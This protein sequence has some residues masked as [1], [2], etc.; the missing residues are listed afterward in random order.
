VALPIG[1]YISKVLMQRATERN[2]ENLQTATD[3]EKRLVLLEGFAH[4]CNLELVVFVDDSIDGFIVA[5]VPVTLGCDVP[6]A[7]N[8]NPIDC[9][10]EHG[11]V[12]CGIREWRYRHH[13]ASTPSDCLGVFKP[14]RVTVTPNS[15]CA[16]GEFP[17]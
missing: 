12:P 11:N 15:G 9:T 10:N 14:I 16:R 17:R 2:I 3:G 6:T 7:L 8:E 1:K 5:R 4:H 13:H